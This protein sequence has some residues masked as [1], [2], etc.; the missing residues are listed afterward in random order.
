MACDLKDIGIQ[1]TS[2]EPVIP[3]TGSKA[4]IFDV[5]TAFPTV[6]PVPKEGTNEYDWNELI[7]KGEDQ[8]DPGIDGNLYAIKIKPRSGHP[9]G[10]REENKKVANTIIEAVVDEDL[11]NFHAIEAVLPYKNIGLI[12][13]DNAGKFYVYMSPYQ[14]PTYSANFEG[15]Q[16]ISS[17]IGTTF[18][19]SYVSRFLACKVTPETA[20][21]NLDQYLASKKS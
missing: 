16:N 18:T 2:C 14:Q 8:T 12:V 9:T 5:D 11:D 6:V 4:Y 1:S 7:G 3:G 15:G 13:S 20:G 10:T 19:L 17:D 21:V